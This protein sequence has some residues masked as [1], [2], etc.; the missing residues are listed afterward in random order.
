MSETNNALVKHNGETPAPFDGGPVA[1]P[2][3]DVL[4]ENDGYVL[5]LDMP[6]ARRGEI[7]VTV[8]EGTLAVKAP[9]ARPG[10]LDGRVLYREIV[11]GSYERFFTLGEGID[12]DGIEA[13]Y[14]NGVLTLRLR[15]S[16]AVKPKEITIR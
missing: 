8:A 14:D 7:S 15:K 13:Q 2:P 4:E 16:E 1:V 10:A 11:R 5:T 6:G 9:L 12:R 3:A